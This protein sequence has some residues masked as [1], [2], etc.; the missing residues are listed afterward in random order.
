MHELAT[1]G[2]EV[3]RLVPAERAGSR[4][5]PAAGVLQNE[6]A[7]ALD[8]AIGRPTRDLGGTLCEDPVDRR[9]LD[10]E[11]NLERVGTA[12]L[13]TR[14]GRALEGLRHR[15]TKCD[16][17]ALKT[18]SVDI[19]DVVAHHIHHCL[20]GPKTGYP[21]KHRTHHVSSPLA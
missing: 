11:T 3:S 8:G 17:G 20:V 19:G 6:E 18:G 5:L 12:G 21:G 1:G 4:V 14:A 9:N 16:L 2:D 15:L 7:V 10:T 13:E